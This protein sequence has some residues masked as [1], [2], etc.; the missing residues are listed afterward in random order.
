MQKRRQKYASPAMLVIAGKPP[1]A[2][3]GKKQIFPHSPQKFQSNSANTS[4]WD[5]QPLQVSR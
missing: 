5:F 1:E 3:K 2:R 4:T